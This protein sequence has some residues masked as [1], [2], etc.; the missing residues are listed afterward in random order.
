VTK[1]GDE[2]VLSVPVNEKDHSAG[3]ANAAV[4][5]VEY[6]D[7]ECP[8]C[9]RA[10]PIVKE[11]QR[12]LGP[13]LRLVFR[14][15]PLK[16]LH[17]H[18]LL[19]AEAAEAAAAQGKFWEMH[20]RLFERQFALDVDN[21]VEYAG[22]LGLDAPRVARELAARTY[23]PQVSED[24][25]SGVRSGVNGTPTFFINGLRYDGRWDEDPLADALEAAAR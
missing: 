14:H 17:E 4:T 16:E 7:F 6:G 3:P 24:F 18:A 11:M 20:D 8:H 13:R 1:R 21:L 25:M 2:A 15:F 19:A 12:R 23:K 22:D 10:W 5:L 9:R